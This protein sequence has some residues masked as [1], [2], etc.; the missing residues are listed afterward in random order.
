MPVETIQVYLK[1][2]VSILEKQKDQ[3]TTIYLQD[4]DQRVGQVYYNAGKFTLRFADVIPQM[5][6]VF[7]TYLENNMKNINGPF[8]KVIQTQKWGDLKA[9]RLKFSKNITDLELNKVLCFFTKYLTTTTTY[10][11]DIEGNSCNDNAV[12]NINFNFP[13]TTFTNEKKSTIIYL[14]TNP[15]LTSDPSPIAF[16][17]MFDNSSIMTNAVLFSALSGY[18][19]DFMS[20]AFIRSMDVRGTS[21]RSL[22]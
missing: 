5:Q 13:S 14:A 16:A 15:Y 17:N 6:Y 21:D 1:N 18:G 12:K 4:R 20:G 11:I 22:A 9:M 2:Q 8:C 3:L 7:C 19:I 10:L